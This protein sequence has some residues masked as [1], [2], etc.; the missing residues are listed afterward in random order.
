MAQKRYTKKQLAW[1]P[2]QRKQQRS[3][4]VMFGSSTLTLEALVVVFAGLALFGKHGLMEGGGLPYLLTCVVIGVVMILT[5]AF[6]RYPWGIA[7]GWSLQ[8]VMIALG[9]LE[10]M[11]YFVGGLFGCIWAYGIIKG[12]Q[13]DRE[14]VQ[15]AREQAEWEAQHGEA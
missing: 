9:I 8:V 2:G 14:N 4:A 11:M 15:R 1:R 6:L 12:K 3:I 13:M 5:C 7:L 10:P